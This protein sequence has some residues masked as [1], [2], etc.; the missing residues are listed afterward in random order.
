MRWKI[1][2]I[3]MVIMMNHRIHRICAEVDI[4]NKLTAKEVLLNPPAM[5]KNP[6]PDILPR[7]SILCRFASGMLAKCC[8]VPR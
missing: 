7:I 3:L 6:A 8:P 5:F 1:A 4:R 2:M